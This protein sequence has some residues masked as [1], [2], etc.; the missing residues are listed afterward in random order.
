MRGLNGRSQS[1]AL[2]ARLA[3]VA[4]LSLSAARPQRAT[5]AKIELL[6]ESL[7]IA[8]GGTSTLGIRFVIDDG[9]HIY[10]R[11]PGE[12]GGAPAVVWTAPT[13]LSVGDLEWPMPTRF[14]APGDTTYGY[15]HAVMLLASVRVAEGGT[16][17]ALDIQ[18]RVEY[19]VCKDVCVKESARVTRALA[20]GMDSP[21]EY[22]DLFANVRATLP[23]AM[24]AVWTASASVGP[25]E[26][27]LTV[28][29]GRPETAG[30]FLP[31]QPDVID[32]GAAQRVDLRP[33]GLSL[34]LKKSRTFSTAQTSLDGLLVRPGERA[35]EI[36]AG[37]R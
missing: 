16:S 21:S 3:C 28:D 9:W 15:E 34:H 27:L 6:S 7:A 24:P 10:W 33:N 22:A 32:D 20:I 23:V 13:D 4:C 18:A 8:S 19:Q 36:I 30:A 5:H 11:N 25:Q 1:W 37:V 12:S 14:A 2:V 17:T 26:L 31:Y 35:V 29:T